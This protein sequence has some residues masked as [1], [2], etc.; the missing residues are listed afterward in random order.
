MLHSKF[1]RGLHSSTT[2]FSHQQFEPIPKCTFYL[3]KIKLLQNKNVAIN[4]KF[5]NSS[6][7]S[8]RKKCLHWQTW[9]KQEIMHHNNLLRNLK[10]PINL[11]RFSLINQQ[12]SSFYVLYV[13]LSV[14]IFVWTIKVIKLTRCCVWKSA[15][16]QKLNLIFL[17]AFLALF[18]LMTM[19][20]KKLKRWQKQYVI[21]ENFCQHFLFVW[22]FMGI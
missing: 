16:F 1:L 22:K 17:C 15:F 4:F 9:E 10:L 21:D 5:H 20:K 14:F 3:K 2:N 11:S 13:S 19:M 8:R 12:F 6:L 18:W 7:Q